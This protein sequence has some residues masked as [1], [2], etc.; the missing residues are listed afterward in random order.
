M[1][2]VAWQCSDRCITIQMQRTEQ[3]WS[4]EMPRLLAAADLSRYAASVH[5]HESSSEWLQ[6]IQRT[7]VINRS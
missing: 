2:V 4:V 1:R 6:V 3:R 5:H 7:N